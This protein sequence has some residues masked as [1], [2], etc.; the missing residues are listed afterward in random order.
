MIPLMNSFW[1][2]GSMNS[3]SFERRQ[4][5]T[6]WLVVQRRLFQGRTP[7]ILTFSA[8]HGLDVVE[9]FKLFTG[10]T[11]SFS[12]KICSAL[13]NETGMS[14][15]FFR[16]LSNRWPPHPSPAASAALS[17]GPSSFLKTLTGGLGIEPRFTAPKAAVLPLD[18]PPN[19]FRIANPLHFSHLPPF[20]T[21]SFRKPRP[22]FKQYDSATGGRSRFFV[23]VPV[24][25]VCCTKGATGCPCRGARSR[26]RAPD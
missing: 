14:R 4:P 22:L 12:L 25:D 7:D 16:N 2:G 11:I 6:P 21:L 24:A 13:S 17:P 8:K 15:D 3:K 23:S 20:F 26:A 10:M 19:D 18:D 5:F 9:V 1:N